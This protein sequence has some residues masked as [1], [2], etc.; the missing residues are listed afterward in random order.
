MRRPKSL[1]LLLALVLVACRR[2]PV[3]SPQFQEAFGLYNQLYARSLDDAYGDPQMAQVADLLAQVDPKSLQVGEAQDLLAKVTAGMAD[4]RAR[5][6]K[7]ADEQR[8]VNAPST[9]KGFGAVDLTPRGVAPEPATAMAPT[10]GMTRDAFTARFGDCFARQGDYEQGD[11]RGEAFAVL[12][13]CVARFPAFADSLV[14]LLDNR[15]SSLVHTKDVAVRVVDAGE[16]APESKPLLPP[17]RAVPPP[18]A[19]APQTVRYLPGAPHP[20]RPPGTPE[21]QAP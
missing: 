12:P 21:V 18:P 6:V 8:A 9:F 10:L 20:D 7:V 16:P 19:P 2:G 17:V 4:Y 1:A 13:A 15:V 5:A 11:K 14:V 3:Q